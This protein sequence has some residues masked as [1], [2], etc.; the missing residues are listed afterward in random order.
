MA[1]RDVGCEAIGLSMG[2][3]VAGLI[4]HELETVVSSDDTDAVVFAEQVH[5][6]VK[7]RASRLD[8]RQHQLDTRTEVLR[9][10]D[11]HL[12]AWEHRLQT[13]RLAGG[14]VQGR[15]KVGRNDR[16]PCNSG[17]KEVQ[18]LSRSART[19]GVAVA[20]TSRSA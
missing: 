9:R 15:A 8:A 12:R 14:R 17:L 20:D 3:G 5:R 7:E 10:K 2:D 16:C 18:A 4:T 6:L 11:E 1:F 19:H 13:Q